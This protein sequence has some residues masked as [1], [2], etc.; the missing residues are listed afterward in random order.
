MEKIEKIT[1]VMKQ[2]ILSNSYTRMVDW[3]KITEL[4]ESNLYE[5]RLY[6]NF[7]I[8][9]DLG[10]E[11]FR[12]KIERLVEEIEKNTLLKVDNEFYFTTINKADVINSTLEIILMCE[13]IKE[14]RK[15]GKA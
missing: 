12:N 7:T 2:K 5:I 1:D 8:T 3:M 13:K 6:T 14:N 11:K 10:M 4:E 15:D 9:D